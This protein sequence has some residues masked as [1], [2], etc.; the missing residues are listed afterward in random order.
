MKQQKAE[1][2]LPLLV[3]ASVALAVTVRSLDVP[4][5]INIPVAKFYDRATGSLSNGLYFLGMY[6]LVA[7]IVPL[8]ASP[9]RR[10]VP[11]A[12]GHRVLQVLVGAAFAAFLV[13]LCVLMTRSEEHTFELQSLMRTSY[14][15]FCLQK[16]K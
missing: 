1:H 16:K 12:I 5:A 4:F 3:V 11:P 15:V 13:Y 9:Y 14:D 2:L 7:V 6:G 8:L 10:F